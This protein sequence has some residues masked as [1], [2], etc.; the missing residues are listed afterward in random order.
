MGSRP[1]GTG[2]PVQLAHL[3][4]AASASFDSAQKKHSQAIRIKKKHSQA[5]RINVVR[6]KIFNVPCR[7]MTIPLQ[8]GAEARLETLFGNVQDYNYLDMPRVP[9][10]MKARLVTASPIS[11]PP[12]PVFC[13]SE[14]RVYK[15][16]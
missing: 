14:S 5:I 4:E 6:V 1:D 7:R 9:A 11:S 16:R 10:E 8:E 15:R 13:G 2:Q 3:Y 12:T